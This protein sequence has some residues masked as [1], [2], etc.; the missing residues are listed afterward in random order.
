MSIPALEDEVLGLSVAHLDNVS[1]LL[2]A[3][4]CVAS[5]FEISTQQDPSRAA[6]SSSSSDPSL[7]LHAL[8]QK[9]HSRDSSFPQEC[10][11]CLGTWFSVK[12]PLSLLS[13][14]TVILSL[15]YATRE[16]H[17]LSLVLASEKLVWYCIQQAV[18][19]GTTMMDRPVLVKSNAE[20][21][22]HQPGLCSL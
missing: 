2:S 16:A 9:R 10:P 1:P 11:S 4:A 17:G 5:P 22:G 21:Q 15:C 3:P 6:R 12:A 14:P 19:V 18:L 8:C 20:H 13:Q 7:L